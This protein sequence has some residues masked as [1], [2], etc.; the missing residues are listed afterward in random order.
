[1]HLKRFW[2]V[3]EAL[4]LQENHRQNSPGGEAVSAFTKLTSSISQGK[5]GISL[6]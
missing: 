6:I 4:K 3:F 2:L 1:M 5:D